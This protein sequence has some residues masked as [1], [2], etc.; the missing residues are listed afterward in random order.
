MT[1]CP[2]NKGER[3]F[4]GWV[5]VRVLQ[6]EK[7]QRREYSHEQKLG[8]TSEASSRSVRARGNSG[9]EER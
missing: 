9:A 7:Q 5:L 1:F 6:S 4:N 3:E 2:I 8:N